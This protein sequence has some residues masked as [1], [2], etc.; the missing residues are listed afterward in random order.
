M[1]DY[2]PLVLFVVLV[3]IQWA[4]I[5]TLTRQNGEHFDKYK[6]AADAGQALNDLSQT[7]PLTVRVIKL[8]YVAMPIELL[9]LLLFGRG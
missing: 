5:A 3:V 1:I 9:L 6:R 4:V 2:R 7:K 8:C